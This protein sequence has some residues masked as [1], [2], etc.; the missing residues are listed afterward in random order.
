MLSVN[1]SLAIPVS[2]LLLL[3]A[4]CGTKQPRS[5]DNIC[6]I[7]DEN[8]GWHRDALDMN[9][10]WGTPIPVAMAIMY[11]E[12]TFRH[13]ARPP[14]QYFLGVIPTGR[15]SSAYG[16]SQ[17]LTSTWND[18][19]RETGRRFASR[20]NFSD[21]IDFIGWYTDKSQ[22]INGISKWDARAQYLAY[23]EGWGG[24]RNRS[25]QQKNW[26]MNVADRV[27]QRAGRFTT[28]Y[29]SCKDNL[30]RRRWLW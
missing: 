29:N 30:S 13:N 16:Y 3:L 7:F 10:R 15:A 26:L 18:Y 20:S 2:A 27:D 11:Q 23:H 9:E 14:M 19:S 8:P 4:G 28:Q 1:R 22:K 5:P 21:A 24:Y 17:A 6:S 12:S 25:Y